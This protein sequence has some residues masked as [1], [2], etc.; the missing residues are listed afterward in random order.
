MGETIGGI[1]EVKTLDEYIDEISR[2]IVLEKNWNEV[3]IWGSGKIKGFDKYMTEIKEYY[4]S[5]GWGR[6]F[7]DSDMDGPWLIL[8]WNK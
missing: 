5:R 1:F 3:L 6:V 4:T 8:R 2:Q 7:A